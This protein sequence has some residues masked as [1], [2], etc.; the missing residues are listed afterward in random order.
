MRNSVKGNRDMKSVV[1]LTWDNRLC[2]KK[3]IKIVE[4]RNN[5]DITFEGGKFNPTTEYSVPKDLNNSIPFVGGGGCT[6]WIYV[7]E[8]H[9]NEN[10]EKWIKSVKTWREPS[11]CRK[12]LKNE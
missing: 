1:K 9:Y 11:D 2:I 8:T 7:N 6:N 3:S 10:P 5:L 12:W 4:H